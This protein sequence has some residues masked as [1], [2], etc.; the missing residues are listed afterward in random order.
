MKEMSSE[1]RMKLPSAFVLNED[2]LLE[3]HD[4]VLVSNFRSDETLVKIWR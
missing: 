4:K 3:V 2:D 1:I